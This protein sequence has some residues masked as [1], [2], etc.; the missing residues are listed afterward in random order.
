MLE[1]SGTVLILVCVELVKEPAC[2]R[3]STRRAL[4]QQV[5][6]PREI[7]TERGGVHLPRAL[8]IVRCQVMEKRGWRSAIFCSDEFSV[9]EAVD[10]V[11]DNEISERHVTALACADAAHGDA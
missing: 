7:A 9:I 2:L 5:R 6:R 11:G 4:G 3:L 1:R 10:S 8:E